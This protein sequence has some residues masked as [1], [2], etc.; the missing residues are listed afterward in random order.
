VRRGCVSLPFL[1]LGPVRGHYQRGQGAGCSL[2]TPRRELHFAHLRREVKVDVVVDRLV[3]QRVKGVLRCECTD[4]G[5]SLG[6][7]L[8]GPAP[9]RQAGHR[10]GRPG[11]C[12]PSP[13]GSWRCLRVAAWA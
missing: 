8:A 5:L 10:A 1:V 11:A 7:W 3:G 4:A 2:W 6:M 12:S 9:S 13:W